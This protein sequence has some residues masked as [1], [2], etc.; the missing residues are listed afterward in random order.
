[1]A[2]NDKMEMDNSGVNQGVMVWNNQGN[3]QLTFYLSYHIF[4]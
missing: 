4:I 2:K 3:I 1:M